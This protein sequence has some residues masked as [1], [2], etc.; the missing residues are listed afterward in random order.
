[1]MREQCKKIPR[2]SNLFAVAACCMIVAV[3]SVLFPTTGAAH[4][5]KEVV[6]SYDQAKHTLEVRIT[7]PSWSPSFHH[8]KTVEIKKN[9]QTLSV[10]E[11]KDQPAQDTFSYFYPVEVGRGD[12]LEVT[13]TC[14]IFGSKTEKLTVP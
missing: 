1:M 2:R 9:G 13:A 14:N 8:I 10:N 5:P 3:L 4:P 7:H 6:L 11:Y 12:V